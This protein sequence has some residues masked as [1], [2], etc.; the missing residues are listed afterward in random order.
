MEPTFQ[1]L[2]N[3]RGASECPGPAHR[4]TSGPPDDLL[5]HFLSILTG[6]SRL[7]LSQLWSQPFPKE[8]GLLLSGEWRFRNQDLGVKCAHFSEVSLVPRPLSR[9]MGT[10]TRVHA[11]TSLNILKA[12]ILY[13]HLQ[14]STIGFILVFF[15]FNL[16]AP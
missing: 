3:G 5:Q 2:R 10:H 12:M 16:A 13:Q 15:L 6:C 4:S 11:R 14:L 7:S 8:A 1:G 9:Q